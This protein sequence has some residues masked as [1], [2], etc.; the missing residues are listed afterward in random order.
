[1]TADAPKPPRRWWKYLVALIAAAF[2]GVAALLFYTT[3]ES[4]QSLVRRRLTAEVERITGGRAQIGSFHTIPFR[5][6]V[7][8]RDITVHGRE[9]ATDV[10]LAHADGIVARLKISSLLRSELAFENLILDQPVIHIAFYP[11]G[12]TNFPKRSSNISGQTSI[13]QLFALSINRFDLRHGRLLWDDQTIPLNLAARDT[14]LQM[15]YSYLHARYNGR[16]LVGSVDTKLLD[17]RPF[18]WM[19]SAE[20]NLASDSAE[21]TSLKWNSGH[22]NLFASGHI[23]DFRH[24]HLRATY[25][26]HLDLTEA[27]SISRRRELRAGDLDL[28]GEGE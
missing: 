10:P 23:A 8:V 1:M 15:D 6:Q 2:F 28:K 11:D 16:L 19:A 20:F 9:A 25:D 24:P 5:F 18:A 22:S 14:W 26:A 27:A 7:E 3:T 17:C 4:F 12:T 13:E 21:V